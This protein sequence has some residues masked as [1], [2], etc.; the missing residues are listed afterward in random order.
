[1]LLRCN[2]LGLGGVTKIFR[3]DATKLGPAHPIIE[4]FSLIFADPPYGRSLAERAITSARAGDWLATDA[5]IVVEEAGDA[6][7]RPPEGF[8]EL[9]RRRYDDSELIFLRA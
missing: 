2:T 1:M 7:F 8:T 9:E 3:R 6:N 5:L 4:P